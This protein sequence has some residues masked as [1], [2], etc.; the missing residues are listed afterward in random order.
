MALNFRVVTDLVEA[1]K[2]WHTLCPQETIF[3]SWDYRRSFNVY[4][5]NEI[6]FIVGEDSEKISGVWPLQISKNGKAVEFFGGDYMEDN[7]L[8]IVPGSEK[9][10][11]E[12]YNY[13]KTLDKPVYLQYIKNT[14]PFSAALPLKDYKFILPLV[15]YSSYEDYI[16]HKYE[17]HNE[18]R[19]TL[20]KK[21][22]RFESEPLKVVK[23][24]LDD[25]EL[26]FEFN[27]KMFGNDSSFA[28]RPFHKEIFRSHL[29]LPNLKP[30]ILTFFYEEKMIAVSLALIYNGSY[31]YVNTGID[32]DGPLKGFS[33]YVNIRNI[34]NAI[35]CGAKSLDS[36]T[37]AYGWKDKWFFDA[38]PQ[39]LF[40][41][42]EDYQHKTE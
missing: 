32:P 12:F 38:S 27:I 26:M 10:I 39:Y 29:S 41:F 3:D 36:F 28:S 22:R 1:E 15:G 24:N 17:G 21:I 34:Q 42:P 4:H 13:L 16:I 7:R 14:D 18:T 35:E 5:K 33:T 20:S 9:Y 19:R 30:E 37:G 23:N 25:I 6:H 8:L 11:E 31:G 40:K 2:L